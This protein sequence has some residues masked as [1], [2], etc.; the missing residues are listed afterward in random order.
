MP[1][2]YILSQ[3]FHIKT[4]GAIDEP[5]VD[6]TADLLQD[7]PDGKSQDNV[8]KGNTGAG[9]KLQSIGSL[10]SFPVIPPRKFNAE[11]FR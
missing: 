9:S 3:P 6:N 7:N 4:T 2:Q 8:I 5:P 1:D 11:Y 10:P